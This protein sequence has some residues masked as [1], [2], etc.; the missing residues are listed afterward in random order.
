MQVVLDE[1]R[2]SYASEIVV[3]LQSEGTENLDANVARMVQWIN[4]WRENQGINDE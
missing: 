2:S 1:A 4:A 3:E